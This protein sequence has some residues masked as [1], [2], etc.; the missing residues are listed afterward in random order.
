MHPSQERF[1][2]KRRTIYLLGAQRSWEGSGKGLPSPE[3]HQILRIRLAFLMHT[4]R[5][6]TKARAIHNYLNFSKV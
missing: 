5:D 1:A 3:Q 2:Q 4:V 6:I